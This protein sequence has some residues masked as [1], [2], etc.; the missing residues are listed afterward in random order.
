V[1]V[2]GHLREQLEAIELPEEAR[3]R[4][5]RELARLERHPL[6]AAEQRVVRTWLEWIVSLPWDKSTGDHLD[7]SHARRLLDK[8]HYDSKPVKHRI[9]YSLAMHE[10]SPQDHGSILCFVGPPGVGKTS[11][12]R[13]IAHAL[14]RRSAR[15][16]V[17]GVRDGA[18]IRG[19]G[20]TCIGATPGIIMR[21][22]SHAG[23]RNPLLMI[24]GIDKL[25]ADYRGDPASAMLG[26]LDPEQNSSFRDQ[27]LDVSFDL[28][29][30]MFITTANTVDTIPGPLL[31]RMEVIQLAG[32][33]EEEKLQIAK[34][35]LVPRHVKLSGLDR[36]WLGRSQIRF[37]DS[38]LKA[39]IADHTREVGVRNL[40][41]EIGTVCREAARRL[42]ESK[43]RRW[44]TV[45]EERARELLDR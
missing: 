6:A 14:G 41:R 4:A 20:R 44:V 11:L 32:Y 5:D 36:T 33:T 43:F 35:H 45:S 19:R 2:N 12:R 17:R 21:A 24:D 27:Y 3:L 30:V 10:F 37:R 7:L 16:R 26:V 34:R 42:A 38:A 13:P 8:D 18:E 31:E 15:I 1:I 28:S 39:I 9:L 25:G 22:L 23:S 29:Q 40:E